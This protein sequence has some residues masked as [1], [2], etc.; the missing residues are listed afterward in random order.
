MEETPMRILIVEDDKDLAEN[1][2]EYLEEKGHELAFAYDGLV[3]LHLAVTER[4]DIIVLD[5]MLPGIDGL[6]LCERLRKDANDSTPILM[7]TARDRLQDKIDGFQSGTDDYLVKPF[8]MQELEMRL[9]ALYKRA[10]SEIC[11][12]IITVGDL[13]A[14]VKT[15]EVIRAGHPIE[16]TRVGRKILLH[17]MRASPALVSRAELEYTIWGH[18]QPISDVLRSHMYTLRRAIDRPFQQKLLHTVRG[19]GYRLAYEELES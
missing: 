15:M 5:I 14:N 11:G 19:L 2:Q 17:L 9:K 4:W 12:H 18:D 7:L 13:V 8:A 3:G 16:L 1:L 10:S 6:K